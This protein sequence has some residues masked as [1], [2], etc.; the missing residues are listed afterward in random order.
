MWLHV[1][2]T[3]LFEILNVTV[4]LEDDDRQYGEKLVDTGQKLKN[5]FGGQDKADFGHFS[6]QPS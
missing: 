2:A 1:N 5:F 4:Y 3:S 6:G